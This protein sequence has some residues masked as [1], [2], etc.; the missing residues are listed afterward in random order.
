M[1]SLRGK[2]A[3]AHQQP[4]L[5]PLLWPLVPCSWIYG[6]AV[7]LRELAYRAHLLPTVDPGVPVVSIGNLTTGGTGKTPIVL[8]L[9][10]QLQAE[11]LKVAIL[12][13]GYGA[14]QPLRYGRPTGPC[15]GD[16]PYLLQTLLPDVPVIVGADRADNALRAVREYAPDVL[17]LDDGYQYL[18][19][20]R[21]VNI[22]LVDGERL[23]GNGHLLPAG[24]LRE[25]ISAL[26][27]A[28]AVW[29]TKHPLPETAYW[30]LKQWVR[31]YAPGHCRLENVP[32]Q[33]SDVL[34]PS[35]NVPAPQKLLKQGFWT[36]FSG[37]AQPESLE[38]HVQQLGLKVT[39]R[40]RFDDHHA[41]TAEDI[42]QIFPSGAE[43]SHLAWLTTLKDWVKI[44]RLLP[45][46]QLVSVYTVKQEPCGP[47]PEWVSASIRSA[48]V[49]SHAPA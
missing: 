2:I 32:F 49:S 48:R 29:V 35:L 22:V 39:S 11:G 42:A 34:L 14:T 3:A 9:A 18:R 1:S 27:R 6:V 25:S 21:T 23:L 10:R 33:T 45:P 5:S 4:E 16:E 20:H 26:Q 47:L 46:E 41:Y 8:A 44:S 37:I 19:L 17:I 40:F 38:R 36:I 24:P 7:K 12:S 43:H 28:D 31:R 15:H 30:R 13:R